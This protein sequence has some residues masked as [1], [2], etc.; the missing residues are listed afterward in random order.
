[1]D[2]DKQ[3]NPITTAKLGPADAAAV[4]VAMEARERAAAGQGALRFTGAG[5][6]SGQDAERARRVAAIFAMLDRS[7]LEEPPAGLA[8]R[9]LA[10]VARVRQQGRFAR[11]VDDLTAAPV[12]FRWTELIAVAAVLLLGLSVLWPIL[13]HTR[14][15][16]LQAQC[17]QNLATAGTAIGSYAH[18]HNGLAPRA[19]VVPGSTWWN[20]GTPLGPGGAVQSN[21]ANLYLL[22]REHYLKPGVLACPEN[23]NAPAGMDDSQ[24]DWPNGLAVS[25]SYQ[26]QFGPAL[27]LEAYPHIILLA[28]KNP[29]FTV[30]S[31]DVHVLR[32][33]DDLPAETNSALH[34][35][36]HGQNILRADGMVLW[37]NS[38]A[39]NIDGHIDNI[40]TLPQVVHYTGTETP[41]PGHS[42]LVP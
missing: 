27:R 42:Q 7:V 22:A 33:R 26:N 40:W 20:V 38:P 28:D 35:S 29:L 37:T 12:A 18:D 5:E 23:P 17:A 10:R 14:G 3:R 6:P 39:I 15:T 13:V 8:D 11:Q 24:V 31:G 9:A 25:Y 2:C 1:M 21:S 41:A 4:D 36:R 30:S 19:A 34:Q 32:F 16:A